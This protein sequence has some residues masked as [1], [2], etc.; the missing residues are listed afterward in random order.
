M[1]NT[2]WWVAALAGVGLLGC[3]GDGVSAY[4]EYD[5]VGPAF[6]EVNEPG[7]PLEVFS[8]TGTVDV[9]ELPDGR[10]EGCQHLVWIRTD[11]CPSCASNDTQLC[12]RETSGDGRWTLGPGYPDDLGLDSVDFVDWRGG[13][14]EDLIVRAQQVVGTFGPEG[15]AP[16]IVIDGSATVM[17]G[18]FGDERAAT[19]H[20]EIHTT[21]TP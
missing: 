13:A 21:R 15:D 11:L 6:C 17:T 7:E 3:G 14:A 16:T 19:I 8:M 12:L 4:G 10:P 2:R 20:C 5:I 1:T 18:I 9:Q